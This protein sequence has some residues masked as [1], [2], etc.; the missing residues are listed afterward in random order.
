MWQQLTML[1]AKPFERFD[2]I[3]AY[4]GGGFLVVAALLLA[5]PPSEL[6]RITARV[7]GL[8]AGVAPEP[9][10]IR[11][12]VE[13]LQMSEQRQAEPEKWI[14]FVLEHARQQAG[15]RAVDAGEC[16]YYWSD[17]QRVSI[18]LAMIF[19]TMIVGPLASALSAPID[20]QIRRMV[21]PIVAKI[22]LPNPLNGL[23]RV[24]RQ[25][26]HFWAAPSFCLPSLNRAGLPLLENLEI[27]VRCFLTGVLVHS[28]AS[29]LRHD[30]LQLLW[31]ELAL[32]LLAVFALVY[33]S[34][35]RVLYYFSR[36]FAEA[37][38]VDSRADEKGVP[39]TDIERKGGL[40]SW[41][42]DNPPK[43]F[44]E[45]ARRLPDP[46]PP[47]EAN[48]TGTEPPPGIPTR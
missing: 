38:R 1:F 30:S 40:P 37:I 22:F 48:G 15:L 45:L 10:S 43:W 36:L 19:A 20:L 44:Y 8:P 25:H 31:A 5:M 7:T 32:A 34:T 14:A 4:F 3:L 9:E 35:R 12:Q 21:G 46:T 39:L 23:P 11:M 28:L 41:F 33:L 2:R 6:C 42:E 16:W 26:P 27:I 18:S 47:K 24:S 29:Y 17:S 13:R